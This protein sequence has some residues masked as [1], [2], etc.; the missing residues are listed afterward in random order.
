MKK[1][2]KKKA[3]PSHPKSTGLDLE[4]VLNRLTKGMYLVKNV[5]TNSFPSPAELRLCEILLTVAVAFRCA[6]YSVVHVR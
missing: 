5:V 1:K 2:S 4:S 6:V 3:V